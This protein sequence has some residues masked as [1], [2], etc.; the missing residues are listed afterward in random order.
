MIHF[1]ENKKLKKILEKRG[2]IFEEQQELE[3]Q[4]KEIDKKLEKLGYTMQRL[5][6]K[7]VPLTKKESKGLNL[8]EFEMVV[9]TGVDKKNGK[10]FIEVIDQV[11][12]FKKMLREKPSK[13]MPKGQ[14]K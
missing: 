4:R 5:K 14:A 12:E 13:E 3:E 7:T 6:D 2:G 11:E 10:P 1:V 9:R 8:K